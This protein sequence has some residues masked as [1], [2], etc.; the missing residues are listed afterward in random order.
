MKKWKVSQILDK[1]GLLLAAVLISMI[2]VSFP[3]DVIY[4]LFWKKYSLGE[5]ENSKE[6]VQYT[7]LPAGEDIPELQDIE[8]YE[9][10]YMD[11]YTF[12]TD[13]IIPVDMYQ[14]KSATDRVSKGARS[15]RRVI[16][17]G[18][19]RATYTSIF[20]IERYLYNRYYMVKL[21]DGNYVMAYLNDGYYLKYRICGSV[22]LPIGYKQDMDA[23]EKEKLASYVKEYNLDEK[24]LMVMFSEERY[25]KW[26]ILNYAGVAVVWIISAIVLGLIGDAV[27]RLWKKHRR[28]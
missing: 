27:K 4:D 9:E 25:V 15:G 13:S 7:G 12:R 18:R 8:Q 11:Y 28:G 10:G 5:I 26:K 20:P 19:T 21:P 17:S 3:A 22:Q 2:A 1:G 16:S 24:T 14:L 6:Y 23:D